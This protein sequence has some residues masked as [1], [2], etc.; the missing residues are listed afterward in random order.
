MK[1]AKTARVFVV[2]EMVEATEAAYLLGPMQ[3]GGGWFVDG[4][5]R[6]IYMCDGSHKDGRRGFQVKQVGRP[7]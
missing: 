3:P 1:G 5:G 2:G 7:S 6:E 4:R